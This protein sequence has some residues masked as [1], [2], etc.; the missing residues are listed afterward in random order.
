V[1]IFQKDEE[2]GYQRK[3]KIMIEMGIEAQ[4][5]SIIIAVIAICR[6]DS[7]TLVLL[8]RMIYSNEK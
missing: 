5:M 3:R 1:S 4:D 2:N 7:E 6:V 8:V